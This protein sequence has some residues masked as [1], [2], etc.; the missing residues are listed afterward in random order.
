MTYFSGME[1]SRLRYATLEMTEISCHPE[2][3]PE[4]SASLYFRAKSRDLFLAIQ[5]FRKPEL[6]H[7]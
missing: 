1:I 7:L 5:E 6:S 3:S 2:R 4:V